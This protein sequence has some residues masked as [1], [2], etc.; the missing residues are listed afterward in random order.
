MTSDG[1]RSE[2]VDAVELPAPT[3]W[4]LVAAFG[5]TLAFAGLVTHAAVSVAGVVVAVCGAVGWWREVLPREHVERIPLRPPA[6]RARPVAPSA[7]V[8][9]HLELGE[10]RHRARIPEEIHPYSAGIR[11]GLAGGVVMAIVACAY[12]LLVHGSVWYPLNLLSAAAVPALAVA[13]VD[14]LRAFS[15]L[16]LLVGVIVHGILSVF[17]GLLY[18]VILPMLPRRPVLWGAT[19]GPLLWSALVWA[20]LG[21]VNPALNARINWVWFILSQVAFG[22][23]TGLIVARSGTVRTMQ[24]WPLA[25]R[26]GLEAGR[27]PP[28]RERRP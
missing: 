20:T 11:G 17:V 23:V 1:P 21:V 6:E 3:A 4:P 26:A 16:G 9:E 7:A 10:A 22:L 13:S 28:G 8:V 14:E 2:P 15:G 5:V 27:I 18:A 12:G 24:T 25:A 19:V